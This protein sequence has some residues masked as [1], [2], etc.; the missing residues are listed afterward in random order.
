[1][2]DL[3]HINY[4]YWMAQWCI[5]QLSITNDPPLRNALHAACPVYLYN[6]LTWLDTDINSF[7][8]RV[9]NQVRSLTERRTAL[10]HEKLIQSDYQTALDHIT[11]TLKTRGTIS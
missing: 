1:M 6:L 10:Q 11:D 8:E 5:N 3:E 7:K 9:D 4:D 2:I